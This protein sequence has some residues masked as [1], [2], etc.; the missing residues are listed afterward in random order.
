MLAPFFR[1]NLRIDDCVRQKNQNETTANWRDEEAFSRKSKRA[2][3][4][5]D[6]GSIQDR[7]S[8]DTTV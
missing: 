8:D 5:R 2:N 1:L 3:K 4:L 7:Q 6:E